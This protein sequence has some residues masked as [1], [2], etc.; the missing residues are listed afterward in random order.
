MHTRCVLHSFFTSI[1]CVYLSVTFG[2]LL[3]KREGDIN[4][5]SVCGRSDHAR[6]ASMALFKFFKFLATNLAKLSAKTCN[7]SVIAT[8]VLC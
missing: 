3:Y 4:F 1:L 7:I 2:S 8:Y 6:L 5:L